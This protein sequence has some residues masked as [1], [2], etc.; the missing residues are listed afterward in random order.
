MK[1]LMLDS[2]NLTPFYNFALASALADKG[3][4]LLY[5][6]TKYT[7]DPTLRAPNN[8]EFKDF[9]FR[10]FRSIQES[11]NRKLRRLARGLFYPI[12][13]L[14]L[15]FLLK[16]WKPDVV[17]IQWSNIALIDVPFIKLI[18]KMG[19]PVVHTV[20]D[21]N[22]L[23]HIGTT[24]QT[25]KVY[26]ACDRI[27]IHSKDLLGDLLNRYP[28]LNKQ[29][30]RIVP[31]GPLQN[32][33][34]ETNKTMTEARAFLNIP[35]EHF[36]VL[37]FGEIKY[38][39]GLDILVSAIAKASESFSNLH[40]LVAGRPDNES[41]IPDFSILQKKEIPHTVSTKFI[42]DEDVW[43]YFTAANT[44]CLP[45]RDISQSGVLFSAIANE[46]TIISTK[47]GALPEIISKTKSGWLCEPEDIDDLSKTIIDVYHQRDKL[48][49]LGKDA[50]VLL[51]K[52]YSWQSIADKT[53][54]V[55]NETIASTSMH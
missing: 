35:R 46:K 51:D 19:I 42:P 4:E 17:H 38:Y 47:V 7:N 26:A 54:S 23:F 34:E 31:H 29:N 32:E 10:L 41:S 2:A 25:Q 30:V 14:R 48:Y 50:K 3:N 5:I 9:Y 6:S 22:P 37:F 40:L 12:D 49:E 33:D 45:Y 11:G 16:Q 13:H 18:K 1:V 55:Y 52:H 8:I 39:K 20:H 43:A 27:I 53:L 44:V 28:L 15:L 24:S 36:V 21:V